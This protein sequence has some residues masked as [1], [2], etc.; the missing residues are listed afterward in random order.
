MN[1]YK[2][3]FS[4]EYNDDPPHGILPWGKINY[5]FE[6]SSDEEAEIK[7]VDIIAEAIN[8]KITVQNPALMRIVSL[9]KIDKVRTYKD[10]CAYWQYAH[11]F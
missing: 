2:L 7:V 1:L 5:T 8:P 10:T 11:Y 3:T 9:P 6:A 4:Y